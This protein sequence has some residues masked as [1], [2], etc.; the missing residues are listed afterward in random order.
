MPSD[1]EYYWFIVCAASGDILLGLEHDIA[2]RGTRA[3]VN[4]DCHAN[5]PVMEMLWQRSFMGMLWNLILEAR[6]K[7]LLILNL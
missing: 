2:G 5:D 1:V 3:C 7:I 6:R 4:V